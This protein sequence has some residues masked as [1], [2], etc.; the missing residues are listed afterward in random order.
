MTRHVRW[1]A[2]RS[3]AC[4]QIALVSLLGASH[5]AARWIAGTLEPSERGQLLWD[6]LVVGQVCVLVAWMVLG[7]G[8]WWW[9]WPAAASIL[10]WVAANPRPAGGPTGSAFAQLCALVLTPDPS[11]WHMV[12]PPVQYGLAV[13]AFTAAA[14]FCLLVLFR[15]AS[16]RVAHLE[17]PL[18]AP[19]FRFSLRTL[20]IVVTLAAVAVWLGPKLRFQS[21]PQIID[22]EG[23][24]ML[25]VDGTLPWSATGPTAVPYWLAI[26]ALSGVF[27]AAAATAIWSVLRPGMPLWRVLI[28]SALLPGLGLVP[29]YLCNRDGDRWL[30][31]GWTATAFVVVLVTASAMRAA[32]FFLLRWFEIP[33][34]GAAPSAVRPAAKHAQF[35]TSGSGELAQAAGHS[36][37]ATAAL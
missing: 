35:E 4:A 14:L 15:A 5:V 31:M 26:G 30:M 3:V 21:Q 24:A 27:A 6:G 19:A 7:P 29:S 2:L 34:T 28:A 37:P 18:D 22:A 16:L 33:V 17:A 11:A 8:R 9:R 36:Q 1:P 20:L 10:V 13:A 12:S 23:N 25:S 32:G